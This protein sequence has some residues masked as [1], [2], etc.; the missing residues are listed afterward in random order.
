MPLGYAPF[1]FF[2]LP[3]LLLACLFGL[4][5]GA[6]PGRAAWRGYLFGLG[7]FGVGCS[8]VFI[9]MY[10]FGGLGVPGSGVLTLLFVAFLAL[11]PALA[12]H[13]AA[14]FRQRIA[15]PWVMVVL[16]ASVWTGVEWL[17]GWV[18]GG[19]PWLNLGYTQTGSP[20]SGAASVFGVY[21]VAWLTALSAALLWSML[22][23]GRQAWKP[24]VF[25]LIVW[26]GGWGLA[27]PQW[28]EPAGEP[29]PVAIVQGNIM[30]DE[31]W[32][33]EQRQQTYDLYTGL[34]RGH[35][36]RGLVVWPETAMPV[37]LHQL[38]PVIAPFLEEARA[39]HTD[40][41]TG[42]AYWDF[43]TR[44][45]YNAVAAMNE[46]TT[47]YLKRHLVAFGEFIPFQEELGMLLRILDVPLTSFSAGSAGQGTLH[48][49][50]IEL[51]ASICFE[52]VFGEEIIDALPA[53]HMLVNLS[54]DAWFGRSFAPHQH[55]QMARMRAIETERWVLR[56]TNTGISAIIDERGVVRI[57][58]PQ[59][60]VHVI[61]GAAQPRQGATPYV[62]WGNAPVVLLILLTLVG[63][64][65]VA[66]K[67]RRACPAS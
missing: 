51:G 54:N 27:Q 7:M 15:C 50:G 14:R 52:I 46:S 26:L 4:W 23:V 55:L 9:S 66:R 5:L 62:R 20:L 37:F 60:Q 38:E 11:Y 19:F 57:A 40:L 28:T 24:A 63:G 58:S 44:R 64:I 1:E 21:G 36:N 2:L 3:P 25:L 33:P 67:N 34:T 17:R 53:A 22:Q 49:A 12:G 42:V 61:S 47:L 39:Q 10:R 48:A 56:S 59:D 8:W 31:K 16:L 65:A 13:V 43:D 18:F 41:I 32:L 35:W 6:A 29:V 45:Y 30:Q